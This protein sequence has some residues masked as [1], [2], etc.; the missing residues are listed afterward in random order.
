MRHQ[1][2]EGESDKKEQKPARETGFEQWE[3]WAK[4]VDENDI[5]PADFVDPEE[6]RSRRGG[7]HAPRA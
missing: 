6:Y 1:S 4:A 3:L 2:G 7:N 5:D